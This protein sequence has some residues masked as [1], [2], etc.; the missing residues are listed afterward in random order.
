MF[1]IAKM[2]IKTVFLYSNWGRLV[3]LDFDQRGNKSISR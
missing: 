1:M 2:S 3:K